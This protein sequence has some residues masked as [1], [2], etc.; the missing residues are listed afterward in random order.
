MIIQ[1]VVLGMVSF[2]FNESG[3]IFFDP[4]PTRYIGRHMICIYTMSFTM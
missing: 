2:S 3:V 4:K 1:V